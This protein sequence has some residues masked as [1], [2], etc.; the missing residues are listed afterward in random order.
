MGVVVLSQRLF[1]RVATGRARGIA[2]FLA[3]GLTAT[4]MVNASP[5][6]SAVDVTNTN[7]WPGDGTAGDAAGVQHGTLV[8]GTGFTTGETGQA[9]SFDGIDDHASFGNVA[10]N[11]ASAD[12]TLAFWL[13]TTSSGRH[14]GI[15]GKRS[16]CGHGSMFDVRLN[17][18]GRVYAELDGSAGG[19]NY[20]Y[21]AST[22]EVNDGNFHHVALVR[23]GVT[24]SIVIDGRVDVTRSSTG[25]TSISNSAALI[26]GK[27]R[28]TGVD[29]TAHLR[30]LLDEIVIGPDVDGDGRP[31]VVDNCPNL[32]NGRQDDVDGDGIGDACEPPAPPFVSNLAPANGSSSP[33][34]HPSLSATY[35]DPNPGDDGYLEF[36]VQRDGA[37]VASSEGGSASFVQPGTAVS[38]QVPEGMLSGGTYTWRVRAFDGANHSDWSSARAL[39]LGGASLSVAEWNVDQESGRADYSYTISA[40]ALNAPGGVAGPCYLIACSWRVEARHSSGTLEKSFGA[41]ASGTLPYDTA[42]M[43][44]SFAGALSEEVTEIRTIVEPGACYACSQARK[45]YDSGWTKV[46]DPYRTGDIS[47]TAATWERDDVS[48]SYSYDLGISASGASQVGGPCHEKACRW[49][50][51]AL[52]DDGTATELGSAQNAAG[53]WTIDESISGTTSGGQIRGLKATLESM[54]AVTSEYWC[55]DPHEAYSTGWVEVSDAM[56]QDEDLVGH[57]IAP[58]GC[59]S[60]RPFDVL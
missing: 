44:E 18:M 15:I 5:V 55:W 23:R 32:G 60:G 26:A 12:F 48:G 54:C 6:A 42:S 50:V 24:A 38:W 17:P 21:L 22:I 13:K 51:E 58:S 16:S 34:P 53:T 10:G 45:Q 4:L 47:L 49:K 27:S 3:A 1:E 40:A 36:E 7:W 19:L 52:F 25:V 59:I 20:S 39:S 37:V 9:F 2:S 29:G 31:N 14:E 43:S 46:A 33:T 11:T 28:C 57:E 35:G 56:V 8:N 41:I 30:G